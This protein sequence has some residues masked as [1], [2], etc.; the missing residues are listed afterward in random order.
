MHSI[1]LEYTDLSTAAMV[2]IFQLADI[3]GITPKDA[4]MVYLAAQAKKALA[5][6]AQERGKA[7]AKRAA[8]D[9]PHKGAMVPTY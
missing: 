4:A 9:G 8:K 7:L 6:A 3:L 1:S 5:A 2:K